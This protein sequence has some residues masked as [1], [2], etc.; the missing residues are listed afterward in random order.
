MNIGQL[1]NWHPS[2]GGHKP[3]RVIGFGEKNRVKIVYVDL[4]HPNG[5]VTSVPRSSL[6]IQGDLFEAIK[7]L[8]AA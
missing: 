8:K 4:G 5:H 7:V 6:T 2:S 1:V 3:A